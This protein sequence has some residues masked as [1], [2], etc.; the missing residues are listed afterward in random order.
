MTN[1][2]V[3]DTNG[4]EHTHVGADAFDMDSGQLYIRKGLDVVA[5]YSNWASVRKFEPH[6][7]S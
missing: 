1:I 2:I 7:Q 6:V 4:N 3:T 5:I